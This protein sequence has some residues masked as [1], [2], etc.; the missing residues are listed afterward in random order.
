MSRQVGTVSRGI[1]MPIIREGDNIIDMVV[2]NVISASQD[3]EWGWTIRDRDIIAVTESIVARAQGNYATIFDIALDVADKFGEI[4]TIGV[5]FPILSRNRFAPCLEG[6][7]L[8]AKEVVIQFSFPTDEMGNEIFPRDSVDDLPLYF[9][10]DDYYAHFKDFVH[11]FTGINYVDYY[12]WIVEGHGASCRII[13]CNEPTAIL[14]YT[15]NVLCCDIHTLPQTI[16]KLQSYSNKVC[17]S[18]IYGIN[19]I[20]STPT[21]QCGYNE[22]YGLLGSNKA[23]TNS[24]KLFP[25]DGQ[26]IV[27]GIQQKIFERTGKRIEVLIYG[28][29]AYK[30]PYSGIWEWADPVVAPFYTKGL[31]GTP[32]ELKIKYLADNMCD[33]LDGWVLEDK[34]KGF[35]RTKKADLVGQ[36]NSEGTTPRHLTDL[37]GSLCDLTSGSGDKG[38]PVVY[39]QGYFDN[40]SSD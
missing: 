35:I 16:K 3:K 14:N 31:E 10:L 23:A 18:K 1:R 22:K 19:Q 7:A 34:I 29:G 8:A 30:D 9:E 11:P 6:I 38:T 40:Y 15:R 25:R 12:K 39:I 27:D 20:L 2:N 5:V 32:N 26:Y 13:F 4:E 17:D 37:V 28:D 36:M 24:I 21:T 33:N